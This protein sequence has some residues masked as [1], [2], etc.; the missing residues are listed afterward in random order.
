L[1]AQP[2]NIICPMSEDPDKTEGQGETW[3]IKTGVGI[4]RMKTKVN[5]VRYPYDPT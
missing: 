3:Y 5:K 4:P 2:E 1:G